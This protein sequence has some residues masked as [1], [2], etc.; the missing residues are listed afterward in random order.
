MSTTAGLLTH[1]FDGVL[2]G[3]LLLGGLVLAWVLGKA[4]TRA[5]SQ[6]AL[7]AA[8]HQAVLESVSDAILSVDAEGRVVLFNAAAERLLGCPRAQALGQPVERFVPPDLRA[9]GAGAALAFARGAQLDAHAGGGREMRALRADGREILVE[10]TVSVAEAHAD[11]PRQRLYIVML[12]DV[13]ARKTAAETVHRL[14]ERYRMIVEQSPEAI[15]LADG[16]RLRLVNRACAELLG[17]ADPEALIGR[18][19]SSFLPEDLPPEPPRS[20]D[21]G[22]TRRELR[23]RRLDGREVEVELTLAQVPDHGGIA[24]QGV[25]R[26]IG[27]RKRAA[28]ALQSTQTA[29]LQA[30]RLARLGYAT[31]EVEAGRWVLAP[32][33]L[34][35]LGLPPGSSIDHAEDWAVVHPDDRA[36][37]RRH[38]DDEVLAQGRPYDIEYRIV[39]A[40]DGRV[41]WLRGTGSVE[42]ADDGRALRLFAT[43]QDVTEAKLSQLALEESREELRRLSERLIQAREDERRHLA[44]ELHDELG[45]RLS[46]LKL[47][48]EMQPPAGETTLQRTERLLTAVD[49]ALTATRRLAADLRPAMLDDLGLQAALGWLA[50]DW[51]RRSG[52]DIELEGEIGDDELSDAAAT[53]L[54]RIVQEALTNVSRHA[55]ASEVR[56]A[57]AREA[58]DLV[59]TVEDNGRGLAPGDV[60]KRES[61]GLAGIRERARNLGGHAR[62]ANRAEGGARLEVRLPLARIAQSPPAG[63]PPPAVEENA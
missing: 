35:L 49:E 43:V 12:R 53:T 39:R 28:E 62:V 34:E 26:D 20:A 31:L 61:S 50:S 52:M 45:Q 1:P 17:A 23:V 46:V 47:E 22:A 58:V 33:M 56:I 41:R 38:L 25:M 57:I 48:L 55:H 21:G 18:E 10:V 19:L 11:G 15:W 51:R 27:E 42:R 37:L 8:R 9:R 6:S 14:S 32:S 24:L 5:R 16:G 36:A 13:A 2:F 40:D 44:R 29:L 59:V 63:P 30:Q 60:D 54:Y 4:L 3:L 7:Q